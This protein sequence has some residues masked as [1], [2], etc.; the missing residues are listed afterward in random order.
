M[1]GYDFDKTIY[2][3]DCSTNFFFYMI[4]TRFYLLIFSPYFLVVFLLY[5]L[6]ILNKKH[7]K[8][9]M[10]FFIPWYKNIDKIVKKFWDKQIKK[11]FPY[12]LENKKEDDV[13]ISAGLEFIV[14]EAMVR[15]KIKNYMATNFDT[16]TGKIIGNN[17]YGTEKVNRFREVYKTEKL[18]AF[19]S[20][21]MSDLP[22]MKISE[23]AFLVNNNTVKQIEI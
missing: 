23:K 21:S 13:I 20:D 2:K 5:G 11:I 1:V 16:K 12:Y 8:Q 17:C 10:Y 18:E 9:C 19:Y 3:G 6:K 15:L 14:K 7:F 4:F 22:M